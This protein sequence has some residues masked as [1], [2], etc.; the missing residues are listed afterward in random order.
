MSVEKNYLKRSIFAQY[1][2]LV[3]TD[4]FSFFNR[5]F[6]S[7]SSTIDTISNKM[8]GP[9]APKLG[10]VCTNT[11]SSEQ[12]SRRF[13]RFVRFQTCTRTRLEYFSLPLS[14]SESSIFFITCEL[15]VCVSTVRD[16]TIEFI[17]FNF[18]IAHRWKKDGCQQ[19]YDLGLDQLIYQLFI[20]KQ[21]HHATF[22]GSPTTTKSYILYKL[23]EE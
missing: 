15:N 13:V 17:P 21:W 12:K 8:P 3:L 1:T 14:Q 23:D 9:F 10:I 7:P 19:V 18:S 6:T 2:M 16:W 20:F 22:V 5:S 4:I 11:P